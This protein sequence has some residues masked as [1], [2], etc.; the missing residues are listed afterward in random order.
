LLSF[1]NDIEFELFS[2]LPASLMLFFGAHGITFAYLLS[3]GNGS[4]HTR[5][6]P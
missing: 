4:T 3:P 1:R 2:T 5:S 6:G